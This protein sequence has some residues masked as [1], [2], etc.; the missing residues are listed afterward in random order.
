MGKPRRVTL[1]DPDLFRERTQGS[2]TFQY[3]EE[4]K[5]SPRKWKYSPS[6]GERKGK[7]PN[8][9]CLQI[10]G[11]RVSTSHLCERSYKITC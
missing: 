8:L 6:S 9:V 1:Y 4:K 3:L 11:C 7:S 10:K 5:K 2:K